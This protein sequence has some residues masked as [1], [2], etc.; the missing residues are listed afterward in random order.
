MAKQEQ[1]M[2]KCLEEMQ[3]LDQECVQELKELRDMY[4]EKI[5]KV[6][7]CVQAQEHRNAMA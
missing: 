1:T 2:A 6:Y 7:A 4:N 5:K 3:Q